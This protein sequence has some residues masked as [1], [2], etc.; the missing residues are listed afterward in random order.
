MKCNVLFRIKNDE[1]KMT[2]FVTFMV[3]SVSMKMCASLREANLK[4]F[5]T[6]RM[7]LFCSDHCLVLL[8]LRLV[9]IIH[10]I[11]IIGNLSN[12]V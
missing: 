1:D 12:T 2:S 9:D 8:Q 10:H 4:T 11:N 7:F 3:S 5:K 6:D